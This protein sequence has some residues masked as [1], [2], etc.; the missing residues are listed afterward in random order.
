VISESLA[1]SSEPLDDGAL[2]LSIVLPAYREADNLRALLP[3][4]LT[5]VESLRILAEI[6]VV[7]ADEATD[8]T[9][10]ICESLEVCCLARKYGP[11]YGS[12]VRTGIAAS[13]GGFIVIMDADG[14]HDP[15]FINELWRSRNDADIVIASRYVK[16]GYTENSVVLVACSRLLNTVFK[17]VLGL[18]ASDV[19]NSF[20]LYHGDMLRN[21]QLCAEHFDIQEEIL[22][23]LQWSANGG[24]CI[25]EL[26]FHFRRRISGKSKRSMLV[27]LWA[28]LSSIYR[29]YYW[30]RHM[31]DPESD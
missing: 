29:L 31:N 27:F 5:V 11:N 18:S 6:V 15:E 10:E 7:D 28:F 23:K 16:G 4:I 30:K 25:K 21:L 19:S 22:A 13:R 20:R 26:P 2:E 3:R 12:A 17:L 9:P 24:V 8:E 14:S 1:T